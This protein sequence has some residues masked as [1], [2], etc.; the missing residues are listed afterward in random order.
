MG[1]RVRGVSITGPLTVVSPADIARAVEEITGFEPERLVNRK[2]PRGRG[3]RNLTALCLQ[4]LAAMSRQCLGAH[5]GVDRGSV[6]FYVAEAQQAM[7]D[8][9]TAELY[10]AIHNRSLAIARARIEALYAAERGPDS[11]VSRGP[12]FA[13]D[14]Q[15]TEHADRLGCQRDRCGCP[16]EPA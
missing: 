3:V 9:L 11:S 13:C 14:H 10:D 4:E 12:C 7:G 2:D 1:A 16:E 15:E 5:L 6:A 8:P